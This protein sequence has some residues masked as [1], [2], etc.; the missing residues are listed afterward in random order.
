MINFN[1]NTLSKVQANVNCPRCIGKLSNGDN[2]NFWIFAFAFFF[3]LSRSELEL[4]PP[5][6][7][8]RH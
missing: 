4:S 5:S 3:F 2:N 6:I 1:L 8:I 7:D